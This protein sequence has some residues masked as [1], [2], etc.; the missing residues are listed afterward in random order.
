MV[1]RVVLPEHVTVPFALIIRTNLV[2]TFTKSLAE[3]HLERKPRRPPRSSQLRRPDLPITF[4]VRLFTIG[5]RSMIDRHASTTSGEVTMAKSLD[6]KKDKKK[7]PQKTAKEKKA[8]KA[9]K[10]A[11]K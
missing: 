11:A 4:G 8:A 9:A 2:D 10:K 1:C 3:G 7:A 5:R 6:T